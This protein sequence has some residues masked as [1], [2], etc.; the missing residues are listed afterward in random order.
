VTDHEARDASHRA[1]LPIAVRAATGHRNRA[2]LRGEL[3]RAFG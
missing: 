1:E 2:A 3:D